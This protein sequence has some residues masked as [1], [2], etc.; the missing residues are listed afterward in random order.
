MTVENTNVDKMPIS[1]P[2]MTYQIRSGHGKVHVI[3]TRD[4]DDKRM[5]QVFVKIT[6]DAD[7]GTYCD[8][9][10]GEIIGRLVS[11]ALEYSASPKL[12]ASQLNMVSCGHPSMVHIEGQ[13]QGQTIKSI[14]DAVGTIMLMDIE[15]YGTELEKQS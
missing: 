7:N 8:K 11:T 3:I 15:Q 13:Q 5:L 4:P 1:L 6:P 12:V 14:A 10:L 2:S 9:T